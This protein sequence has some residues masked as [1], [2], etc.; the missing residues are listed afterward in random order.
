MIVPYPPGIPTICPGEIITKDVWEF[1]DEQSKA[2]RHLHGPE[3]GILNTI[4]IVDE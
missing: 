3:N 4:S 1:L 2:G